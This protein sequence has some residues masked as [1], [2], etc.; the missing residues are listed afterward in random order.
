MRRQRFGRAGL[1]LLLLLIYSLHEVV[2]DVRSF[3]FSS[4]LIEVSEEMDADKAM[5]E[6][7]TQV[8]FGSSDYGKSL[9]DFEKL[10]LSAVTRKPR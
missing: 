2:S 5:K 3:A 9:A 1:G 10:C 7:M 8:G 4:H 6:I